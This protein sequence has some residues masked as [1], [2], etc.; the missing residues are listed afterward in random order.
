MA[1]FG[2]FMSSYGW[3]LALG[4]AATGALVILTMRA[5]ARR[6]RRNRQRVRRLARQRMWD[7]LMM[8]QNMR[9]LTY[10]PDDEQL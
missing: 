2:D 10:Q 9:R 6:D 8:R 4:A 5:R 7:W 3:A 1:N